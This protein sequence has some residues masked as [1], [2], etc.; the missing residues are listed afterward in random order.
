MRKFINESQ[1]KGSKRISVNT[2]ENK[3]TGKNA[4]R[5]FKR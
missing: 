5:L 2:K 3:K 1:I 4:H